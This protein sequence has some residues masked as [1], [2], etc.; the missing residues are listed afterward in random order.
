MNP[1]SVEEDLELRQFAKWHPTIL[2]IESDDGLRKEIEEMFNT[3][4]CKVYSAENADGALYIYRKYNFFD[5]V[6]LDIQI[7]MMG[8]R[9]VFE[10][11]I[12]INPE[13][14]ILIISG[15]VDVEDLDDLIKSGADG[16]LKKPFSM[17]KI[18]GKVKD[19]IF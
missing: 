1:F 12:R 7:P 18:I 11:I 5:L 9:K 4:G 19:I 17:Y 6:I 3:L 16:L 15:Y 8:G 13:Q 10:E 14:K 2:I